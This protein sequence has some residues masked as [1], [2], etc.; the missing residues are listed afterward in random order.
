[1]AVIAASLIGTECLR[2]QASA[3]GR[4]HRGDPRRDSAEGVRLGVSLLVQTAEPPAP[5]GPVRAGWC[6][7]PDQDRSGRLVWPGRWVEGLGGLVVL[8]RFGLRF[9]FGFSHV[10]RYPPVGRSTPDLATDQR[11]TVQGGGALD[12]GAPAVEKALGQLEAV[13]SPES[14]HASSA[15]RRGRHLSRVKYGWPRDTPR[16]MGKAGGVHSEVTYPG[17][18]RRLRSCGFTKNKGGPSARGTGKPQ[19]PRPAYSST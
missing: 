17:L 12:S 13:A 2:N 19:G 6:R 4:S 7:G 16:A 8:G 15:P 14:C 5:G 9:K 10:T 11:P 1:M 3:S 18:G